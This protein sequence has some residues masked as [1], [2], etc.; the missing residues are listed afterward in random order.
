[1]K[2]RQNNLL[3]TH[4]LK[5]CSKIGKMSRDRN[6]QVFSEIMHLFGPSVGDILGG[7]VTRTARSV[8]KMSVDIVNEEKYLYIYAEIPGVNKENIDIDFYNNKLTITV[9]KNRSYE[10]PEVSEIKF[11]K[12]ERVF[13]LPICVTRK[14]T[15]T[16][17]YTN[18]VLNIRLLRK[19]I[20]FL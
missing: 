18:G 19:K 4:N 7:G 10:E 6:S 12:V 14:D 8:N 13:T 3:L 1:M 11:G 17:C 20:N 9:E 16:V 15:V 5:L 2:L